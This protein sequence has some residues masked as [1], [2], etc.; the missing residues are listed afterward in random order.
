MSETIEWEVRV[1]IYNEA[2]ESESTEDC[3]IPTLKDLKACVLALSRDY[4]L[5][6]EGKLKDNRSPAVMD[7]FY[8]NG[9]PVELPTILTTTTE[10][11]V[12]DMDFVK[13]LEQQ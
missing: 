4:F 13:L 12:V 5:W 3:I 1:R 10:K 11:Q 9:Y 6:Q 7:Y 2:W 8:R